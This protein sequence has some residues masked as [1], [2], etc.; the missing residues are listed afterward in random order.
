MK[1]TV[2]FPLAF[3]ALA[4]QAADAPSKAPPDTEKRLIGERVGKAVDL[5][6]LIDPATGAIAG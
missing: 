1:L 5:L 6:P 2:L 3:C 4:L